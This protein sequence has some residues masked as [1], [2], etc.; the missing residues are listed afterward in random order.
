MIKITIATV[1]VAIIIM[2]M[3]KIE[4]GNRIIVSVTDVLFYIM[5]QS[6]KINFENILL[7]NYDVPIDITFSPPSQSK[8]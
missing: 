2:M 8:N 4:I 7:D 3:M 6:N 5:T 1:I